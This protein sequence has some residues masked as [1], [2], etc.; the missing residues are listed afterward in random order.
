MQ[1]LYMASRRESTLKLILQANEQLAA[2]A[3]IN[4]RIINGLHRVIK[5]EQKRRKQGNDLILLAKRIMVLNS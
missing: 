3:E 2:Q 4:S 1:K 5:L